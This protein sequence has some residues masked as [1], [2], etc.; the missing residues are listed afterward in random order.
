MVSLVFFTCLQVYRAWCRLPFLHVCR[1]IALGAV[2]LFYMPA[3][4]S[5]LVPFVFFTCL[6]V[7]RAWCRLSFLHVY[8]CFAFCARCVLFLI[9]I[10]CFCLK[11]SFVPFLYFSGGP[12]DHQKTLLRFSGDP[13]GQAADHPA[14][15]Q[16]GEE[17]CSDP[18][19]GVTPG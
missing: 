12:D 7:Y 13:C 16:E 11:I 6:Q 17:A 10:L 4:V 8:R 1:C 15:G 14:I 5:R 19:G 2:C 9:Q 3:G 18:G